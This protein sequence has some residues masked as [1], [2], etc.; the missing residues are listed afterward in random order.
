MTP[1]QA[2]RLY[3]NTKDVTLQKR[4]AQRFPELEGPGTS[5]ADED[6]DEENEKKKKE[7]EK[8]DNK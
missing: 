5:L 7:K 1:A 8:E 6:E 2:R 4:L 3:K